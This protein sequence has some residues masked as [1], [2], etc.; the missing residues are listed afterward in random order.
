MERSIRASKCGE[1]HSGRKADPSSRVNTWPEFAQTSG[2]VESRSS[3][4]SAPLAQDGEGHAVEA[5]GDLGMVRSSEGGQVE[6][7]A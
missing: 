2:P 1:I 5:D 3:L 6:E 4:L 7:R